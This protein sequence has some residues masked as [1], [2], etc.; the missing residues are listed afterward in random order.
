MKLV[1]LFL[2][3][4]AV[5]I[6]AQTIDCQLLDNLNQSLLKSKWTMRSTLTSA[7]KSGIRETVT[8]VDS[9]K[10]IRI[11]RKMSDRS[12]I[13]QTETIIID[14][15]MYVKMGDDSTWMYTPTPPVP[16]YSK[17]NLVQNH[18]FTQCQKVGSEVLDGV[19]FDIIET[20]LADTSMI[21]AMRIW[22]NFEQQFFKKGMI[23][24]VL[25][26]VQVKMVIEYN[27]SVTIEKPLKSIARKVSTIPYGQT[28]STNNP[29]ADNLPTF[30][31]GMQALFPF[32]QANLEYPQKAREAKIEGTVYVGF[33]VEADGT[34]S[35]INIKRGIGH[36]CDEAAIELVKKTSG[37]WSP[38]LSNGKPVWS[39]YTL[40]IRFKL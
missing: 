4:V 8:E 40:P 18:K 11:I 37:K 14:S 17:M 30:K 35:N 2:I 36:G 3:F 27:V 23:E 6:Q 26:G 34:V 19:P 13:K 20:K 7:E 21:S 22:V 5:H 29:S 10:R 33:K 32:L 16:D 12:P 1:T 39:P 28:F 31:D 25:N 38:A 15:L 9:A 24:Q